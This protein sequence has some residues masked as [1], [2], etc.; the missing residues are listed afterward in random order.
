IIESARQR[1]ELVRAR[2]ALS[3]SIRM[4]QEEIPLDLIAVEVQ[5]ALD[6]LGTLTGEVT[7]ADILE[8]IFSGF[9]VG[10]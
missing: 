10:K 8:N 9:C 5:E 1:D 7:S 3:N 2:T 4:A 6:A